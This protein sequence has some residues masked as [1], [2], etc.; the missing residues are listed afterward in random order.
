M[1]WL[2]NAVEWWAT[3]W[4]AIVYSFIAGAFLAGLLI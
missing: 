3:H 2:D 4:R 1:D